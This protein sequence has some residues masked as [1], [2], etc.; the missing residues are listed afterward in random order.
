M[1]QI[2]VNRLLAGEQLWS[3]VP[4]KRMIRVKAILLDMVETGTI[5]QEKF[6]EIL[7]K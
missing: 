5:T 4:E 2:W 1:D 6:D 3:E 7:S